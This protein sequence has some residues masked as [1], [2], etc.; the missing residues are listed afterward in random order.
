MSDQLH[1]SPLDKQLPVPGWYGLSAG[2]ILIIAAF[3]RLFRLDTYLLNVREANWAYD[4]FSFFYGRPLPIGQQL[5]DSSP[6]VIV[7]N[8]LGL[9]LFGVTDATARIGSAV[10]GVGLIAII[11]LLRPVLTRA[12]ILSIAALIAVSPTMVFASRTVEPGILAAFFAVLMLVSIVRIGVTSKDNHGW[13][14]LLGCAIAALYATGPLGVSTLIALGIGV[15]VVSLIGFGGRGTPGAVALGLQR[16]AQNRTMLVWMLSSLVISLLVLFTRLFTSLES[17]EGLATTMN[18][19]ASMMTSGAGTVP[20][21]FHFWS[22]MLYETF[23]VLIAL[24]TAAYS[25]STAMKSRSTVEQIDPLLYVIWFAAVLLLHTVASTRDTGS[26]VLVVL[27]V[28]L[29]AG[30]GFGRFIEKSGPQRNTKTLAAM[31]AGTLLIVYSVNAMIGLSFTRGESGVEPLA[32][33]TPSAET[34]SFLDQVMRLSRDISVTQPNPMDPT[35]RFGLTIQASPE[36]EWP[37]TWYFRDFPLF[38]V[39]P[40]GAF[41]SETDVAIAANS[42]V[43]E[44]VGLTP[45]SLVWNHKPG[46]PLTMMR[47]GTILQ[48]GLNPANWADAWNYMIHR[49]AERYQNPR[50]LT[51]GYSVRLMNKLNTETG[52]FNLFDG[53]SPGLGGGLGQLDTPAGIAVGDD[54]TIYVLNAGNVRIDRFNER[55][56]FLGIWSGQ[57]DPGLQLSWNGFQGGTGLTVG[58]D[59]LIYIADTW[60][61]AVVVVNP[62]GKVVRVLGDRGTQTDITDAGDPMTQ[63]GLFFGPRNV[64]I[65]SDRIYV[66]D[67]GNERVQVFAMDGTFLLAFGGYGEDDGQFIEPTGIAIDGGGRIWVADSGNARLQVFDADGKWLESHHITQ[68]EDQVGTQRMNMLAFDANNILYFTTPNQGIWARYNNNAV[69]VYIPNPASMQPGGIAIDQNGMVLVTSAI[70]GTVSRLDPIPLT[71]F[72]SPAASPE[73]SPIATPAD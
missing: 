55:G 35:G 29:L 60:N 2:V 5:P 53:S 16:L 47:S 13:S 52:P 56:E 66:T 61:H 11:F 45:A 14:I 6:L 54:G 37:F 10:I 59:G 25:R 58:P 51:Y 33:D 34:R 49:D 50:T 22:L 57:V 30:T 26:A 68:W 39:T 67:T 72:G 27:P 20:A 36:Y 1:R 9:F 63:Q 69:E 62:S 32:H 41:T 46:D 40:P 12:Q 24:I 71:E 18:D 48:T 23:A 4:A 64:A 21:M 17:L 31:L 70:D 8:A 73:A 43:M 38:S 19:W 42:E 3:V 65:G 28:L 44:S 7:W 15:L